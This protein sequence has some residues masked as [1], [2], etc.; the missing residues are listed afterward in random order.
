MLLLERAVCLR[1]GKWSLKAHRGSIGSLILEDGIWVVTGVDADT[2]AM[3]P[4][5][6]YM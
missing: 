6:E 1:R 5:R 2:A 4:F 3:S